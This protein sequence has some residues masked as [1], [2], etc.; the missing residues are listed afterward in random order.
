MMGWDGEKRKTTQPTFRASSDQRIVIVETLQ[1]EKTSMMLIASEISEGL[2]ENI[3]PDL[4]PEATVR[5]SG[6][7]WLYLPVGRYGQRRE[8]E[9]TS[10]MQISIMS[11]KC[12]VFYHRYDWDHSR[13]RSVLYALL[14]SYCVALSCRS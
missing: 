6:I 7:I 4:I 13:K 11:K 5:K 14:C 9:R 3:D 10:K 12:S 1:Y 8:G 2:I